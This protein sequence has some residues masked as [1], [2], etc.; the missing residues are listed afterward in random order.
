MTRAEALSAAAGIIAKSV[1]DLGGLIDLLEVAGQTRLAS[2]LLKL[3][4]P[5]EVVGRPQP[6]A[7]MWARGRL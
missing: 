1:G 6:D 3:K 5:P 4:R 2:A 7:R